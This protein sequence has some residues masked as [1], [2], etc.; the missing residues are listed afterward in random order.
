[1]E[2]A[3]QHSALIPAGQGGAAPR[4]VRHAAGSPDRRPDRRQGRS[5]FAKMTTG[6]AV[7]L[8]L[9][10]GAAV[11]DGVPSG[12]AVGLYDMLVEPEAAIARFR[13]LAPDLR[14]LDFAE[15]EGDL[16]WLCDHVALPEVLD[17]GWNVA[18]IIISI[19]DREVPFGQ[20]DPEALQYF[21]AFSFADG[22][23]V[24]EYF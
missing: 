20:S 1:M 11:A 4:A 16:P 15:V 6:A 7:L 19:G 2:E 9:A 21:E 13:F 18:E 17:A 24:E 12:L 22:T 23:C 5:T 10:A 3:R 8:V 14:S